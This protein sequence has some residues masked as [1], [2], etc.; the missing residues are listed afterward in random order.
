MNEVL[1]LF[2]NVSL[3]KMVKMVLRESPHLWYSIALHFLIQ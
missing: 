3:V 2:G 1:D